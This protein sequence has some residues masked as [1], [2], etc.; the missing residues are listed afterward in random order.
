MKKMSILFKITFSSILLAIAVI[1]SRFLSI[2]LYSIGLPFI[3]I[4]LTSSVVMFGSFY[5]GPLYGLI[6][7]A[8]QDFLGALIFPQG[9]AYN[10]L[11]TISA[12]LCGL[13]PYYFYKLID[14]TKIERKY[15]FV[16]GLILAMIS[17]YLT[18]FMF[19]RDSIVYLGHEYQFYLW[20]KILLT[21]FSWTLSALYIVL[22]IVLKGKF[23][24]LDVMKY[25]NI[26]TIGT[27]IFLTYLVRVPIST[28]VFCIY[29]NNDFSLFSIIFG[30]RLLTSFI[31][32]FI[33]II[34]IVI[35]LN[36]SL[37]FKYKG[38]LI[39]KSE[40]SKE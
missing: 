10:P 22:V 31:L 34:V 37:K 15:P 6:I 4:S 25:Y 27:A 21:C 18:Y 9:G 1:L 33:D 12:A 36:V 11:F 24:K 38:A 39:P 28:T 40:L 23:K 19:S 35:G 30:C 3:K 29:L 16:L 26:G 14:L 20:V 8:G 7:G 2:P 5:L 17:A 32:G 13:L